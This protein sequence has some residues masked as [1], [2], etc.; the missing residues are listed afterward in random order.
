MDEAAHFADLGVAFGPPTIDLDKLRTHKS[1]VV[2]KLT[3]GL[4]VSAKARKVDVVRG[5]GHFLDSHH[6]EVELTTDQGR[7]K[8]ARNR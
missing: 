2:S 3:G 1:K 5:Y 7:I 8:P 6:V 4:A